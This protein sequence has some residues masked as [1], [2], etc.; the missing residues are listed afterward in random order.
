MIIFYCNFLFLR[1]FS[2]HGTLTF[3]GG[4][5]LFRASFAASFVVGYLLKLRTC[6]NREARFSSMLLEDQIRFPSHDTDIRFCCLSMRTVY[7]T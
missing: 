4:N 7:F 2:H 5:A 1:R 6:F 3:A